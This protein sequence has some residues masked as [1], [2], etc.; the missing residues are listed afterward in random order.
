[1]LFALDEVG[2]SS[3]Q[4]LVIQGAGGLGLYA[5]AVARETGADV[6]MVEGSPERIELAQRFGA[7]S[8]VD[9]RRHRTPDERLARVRELVGRAV[10]TSC[11][12]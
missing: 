9:M 7:D 3:G 4:S 10:R 6:V 2:L 8:V 5:A 11:S 12:R 1:M